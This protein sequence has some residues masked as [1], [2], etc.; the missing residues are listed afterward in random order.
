LIQWSE[1]QQRHIAGCRYC[2]MVQAFPSAPAAPA[3]ATD[4]FWQERLRQVIE[5][6][7]AGGAAIS[8]ALR[9][10]A[11]AAIEVTIDAV[12]G[13]AELLDSPARACLIPGTSMGVSY[14]SVRGEG[15]PQA[16]LKGEGLSGA[17]VTIGRDQRIV[18]L[19]FLR[20]PCPK[21]VLLIPADPEA[22]PLVC[23]VEVEGGRFGVEIELDAD[24]E[25][26]LAIPL[27]E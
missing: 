14:A 5:G 11:A 25:Y 16:V 10:G 26:L 15:S 23:K 22:A 12:E 6:L 20:E 8:A 2:Q 18:L 3:Q 4:L 17:R 13:L 24:G 27:P 19:E 21:E 7:T 1:D 9:A